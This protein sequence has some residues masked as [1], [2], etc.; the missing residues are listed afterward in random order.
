MTRLFISPLVATP[1]SKESSPMTHRTSQQER[2]RRPKC[3]FTLVELLVVIA[4][5]GILIALL[6]PA[7]QAAREAARRTSCANSL[8]QL[9]LAVHSHEAAQGAFPMGTSNP[10]GPISSLPQGDHISWIAR[11]LGYLEQR[12][13]YEALDFSAGAYAPVNAPVRSVSLRVLYCASDSRP[14]GVVASNYAACHHDVE[15]PI[16]TTNQGVFYLNSAVRYDDLLDGSGQTIFLGEK[17]IAP[18]DLGWLS[19]TRAT[20][21]NT[22]T[23]INGSTSAGGPLS[24]IEGLQNPALSGPPLGPATL[25]KVAPVPALVVGGFESRHPGVG[26]FAFGDGSVRGLSA[27]ISQG[28]YQRLGH[29]ADR[30]LL[31]EESF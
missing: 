6:L 31:D 25:P 7:V 27:N 8:A 13:A 1:Q 4:I 14:P 29:R 20:L 21:R 5:I 12:N 11:I 19:G 9:V 30:Q 18:T 2:P 10:A 26:M 28:V 3:G 23:P 17:L 24:T 16:D 22:G 15:A